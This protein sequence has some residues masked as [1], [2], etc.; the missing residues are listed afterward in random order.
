VHAGDSV[1]RCLIEAVLEDGVRCHGPTIGR[2]LHLPLADI[3]VK[4]PAASSARL[5][6]GVF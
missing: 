3:Q 4:K 2:E 1:G 6:N 5:A